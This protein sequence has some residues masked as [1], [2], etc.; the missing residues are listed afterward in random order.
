MLQR[1]QVLIGDWLAEHLKTISAKYDISF[2][3]AIRIVLCLQIPKLVKVAYPKFNLANLDDEMVNHIKRTNN[4]R[5]DLEEFHKYLSKIYFEAH[6]A[7][8][9]WST[10]ENKKKTSQSK[11]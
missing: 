3:E 4:S 7:V 11:N 2:S 9:F 10:E 6:K 8:E 1:Y 5:Q